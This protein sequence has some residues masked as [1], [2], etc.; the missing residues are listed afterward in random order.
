MKNKIIKLSVVL[1]VVFAV[2]IVFMSMG[3]GCERRPA[4]RQLVLRALS[5]ARKAQAAEHRHISLL[6]GIGAPVP[7]KQTLTVQPGGT[8]I[9]HARAESDDTNT[10]RHV[11]ARH[12]L[13]INVPSDITLDGWSDEHVADLFMVVMKEVHGMEDESLLRVLPMGTIE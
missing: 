9:F 6:F 7:P 1:V 8:V 5:D 2:A 3:G 10:L 12:E 4:G 11:L 13:D